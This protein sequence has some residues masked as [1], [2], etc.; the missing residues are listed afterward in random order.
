MIRAVAG[1]E[2]RLYAVARRAIR[3]G[4]AARTGA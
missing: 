4:A 1:T 2:G 3:R